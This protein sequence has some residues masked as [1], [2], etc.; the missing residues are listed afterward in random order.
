MIGSDGWLLLLLSFPVP[1][2]VG[3][4]PQKTVVEGR[5]VV[6]PCEATGF[7]AP[8]ITWSLVQLGMQFSNDANQIQVQLTYLNDLHLLTSWSLC[9]WKPRLG[10]EGSCELISYALDWI[11]PCRSIE[12]FPCAS[13]CKIWPCAGHMF[14]SVSSSEQLSWMGAISSLY[15]LID[16]IDG[17]SLKRSCTDQLDS[18]ASRPMQLFG[19]YTTDARPIST[20]LMHSKLFILCADSVSWKDN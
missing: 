16:L 5:T 17:N 15:W 19:R 6:L 2:R 13:V 3:E 4:L 12:F 10:K 7:P 20:D 11:A 18:H 1:P 8:N 9:A 14:K